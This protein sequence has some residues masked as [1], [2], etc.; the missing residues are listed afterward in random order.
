[1][2]PNRDFAYLKQPSQCMTTQTARAVNELFRRHL[3]TY[4]ITFHG[5]MRALT[6]EWGSRNHMTRGVHAKSTESPDDHAFFLVGHTMQED[7]GHE[8]RGTKQQ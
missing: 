3:F 4:M 1:M 8:R 6:Y 7:A 2:D 5:G